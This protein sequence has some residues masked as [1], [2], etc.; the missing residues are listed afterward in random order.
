[1]RRKRTCE[2]GGENNFTG[3]LSSSPDVDSIY[4]KL[5]L[6][7]DADQS[8]QTTSICVISS[9]VHHNRLRLIFSLLLPV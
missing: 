6:G 4:A 3:P 8:W 9:L 1:M 7:A 2:G 5:S